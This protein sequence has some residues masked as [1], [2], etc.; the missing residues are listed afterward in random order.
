M[1]IKFQNVEFSYRRSSSKILNGINLEIEEGKVTGIVGPSGSGKTTMI[2][3]IN[4]L[5]IPTKGKVIVGD[6]IISSRKKI[7]NIR[8]FRSNIGLVFQ[9][10]EEQFFCDTVEKEISFAMEQFN[11]SNEEIK[12]SIKK[13]LEIVELDESFLSRDP[14]SLSNGEMRK[15]AIASILSYDPE[16]LILDEPTIGLDMTSKRNLINI[17]TTIKIRY[18]KTIIVVSHDVDFINTI[19]DNVVILKEG[20]ILVSGNKYDVFKN[21]QLLLENGIVLPKIIEFENL[22]LVEKK[23]RLGYRD[24]I[25]DLVK[26]IL[27]HA[28]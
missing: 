16:V 23:V 14:F 28:K 10:A 24:D 21:E 18:N 13:V 4:A 8:K 6:T 11:Y 19:S 7:E 9:F 27:R 25:N 15:V 26:D 17:L 12:N 22:V 2:E 3:M 5:K 1:E 20:I